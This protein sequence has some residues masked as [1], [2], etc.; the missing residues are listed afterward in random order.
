MY[1]SELEIM[2]KTNSAN[3]E[4]GDQ[5]NPFI[6]FIQM[7]ELYDKLKLINHENDFIRQYKMRPI[8]RYYSKI[9]STYLLC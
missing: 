4:E 2:T 5:Q 8:N 3:D 1:Q 6:Q 9:K 7:E